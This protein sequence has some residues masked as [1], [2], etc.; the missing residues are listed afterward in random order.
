MLD[1]RKGMHIIQA[2]GFHLN[3]VNV[4]LGPMGQEQ[5]VIMSSEHSVLCSPLTQTHS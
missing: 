2:I 3:K 1:H 4:S 5:A